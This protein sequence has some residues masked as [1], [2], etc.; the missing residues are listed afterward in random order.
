MVFS[1]S[2]TTNLAPKNSKI[3]FLRAQALQFLVGRVENLY[4]HFTNDC[5]DKVSW[6]LAIQSWSRGAVRT[7]AL[8][9]QS[10]AGQPAPA[11]SRS[12]AAGLY[13][14]A[15]HMMLF[16]SALCKAGNYTCV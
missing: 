4:L 12:G 2:V 11:R 7:P 6:A 9:L 3:A 1:Y 16:G 8:S 10:G 13:S 15:Q 5:S 14:Q